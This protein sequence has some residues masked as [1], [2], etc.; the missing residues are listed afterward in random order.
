[1]AAH[2]ARSL[3]TFQI[4][5]ASIGNLTQTNLPFICDYSLVAEN[6]AKSAGGLLL[7]RP[8]VIGYE[9]QKFHGD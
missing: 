6:Y 2:L 3:G 4:T 1:M 8:Q 7:V 5:K 9:S